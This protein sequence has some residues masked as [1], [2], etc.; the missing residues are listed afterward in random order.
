[1]DHK[2]TFAV[3]CLHKQYPEPDRLP[4]DACLVVVRDG[5]V[6]FRKGSTPT[7]YEKVSPDLREG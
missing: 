6:C 4:G 2:A 3:D 1:M 5:G 7:I